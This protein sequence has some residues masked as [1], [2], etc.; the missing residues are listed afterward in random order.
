MPTMLEERV[1][2]LLVAA[3]R[4]TGREVSIAEV[5]QQAADQGL[6]PNT[7]DNAN[8]GE[9]LIAIALALIGSKKVPDVLAP[10]PT[11]WRG[12]GDVALKLGL[13]PPKTRVKRSPEHARRE[14]KKADAKRFKKALRQA[15]PLRGM[16]LWRVR[17]AIA[18]CSSRPP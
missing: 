8:G 13:L 15:K 18:R 5:I 1:A 3:V 17:N 11:A 2:R 12:A 4:A 6:T 9:A 10:W 14:A 16:A 7:V